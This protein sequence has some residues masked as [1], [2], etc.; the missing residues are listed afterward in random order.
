MRL[1]SPYHPKNGV[2]GKFEK[3][4]QNCIQHSKWSNM[5]IH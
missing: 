5:S 1:I 4:F 2:I 3:Y